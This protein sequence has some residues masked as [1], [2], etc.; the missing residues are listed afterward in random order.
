MDSLLFELDVPYENRAPP[1]LPLGEA[2]RSY[3]V[4]ALSF[5]T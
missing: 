3:E 4:E 5:L 1:A 2:G